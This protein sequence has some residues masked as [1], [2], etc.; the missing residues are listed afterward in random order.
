MRLR[1]SVCRPWRSSHSSRA[2][3][4]SRCLP[5]AAVLAIVAGLSGAPAAAAA[6]PAGGA[7]ADWGVAEGGHFRYFLQAHSAEDAAAF[8]TAYGP[9]AEKALREIGLLFATAPTEKIGVYVYEDRARFDAAVLASGRSEIAG[10]GDAAADAKNRDISLFFPTL[11]AESAIQAENAFRHATAHIV[12]AIAS[13]GAIPRGFDEGIAQ[14]VERPVNERIARTVALVQ[15]AA[16]TGDRTSWFDINR[17]MPALDPD[18]LAAQSYAMTAFL[19]DRYDIGPMRQFLAELRTTP[20]WTEAMRA[21]YGRPQ[22][23][24]ESQWREDLPRWISVGWRKNL[25]AAFDL[26]PAKA[27]LA[28]ANYAAAKSALDPSLTLYRQLDDPEALKGVEGLIAQCDVGIQSESLMTQ[29]Q[30]ALEQ[31]TYD[32]AAS[33]LRQ[34]RAQYGQLPPAQQPEQLLVAYERQAADGLAAKGQL[35]A[36]TLLSHSWLDYR[37]AQRAALSAGT[38]Y[39]RLGDAEGRA[40]AAGLLH[41]LDARQRR[42]VLLLAA[43]AVL[44]LGWLALWLWARGRSTLDWRHSPQPRPQPHTERT[45]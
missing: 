6:P 41:D 4:A 23:E 42:I 16:A 30:Q 28:G 12:T 25:V 17:W 33:L 13:G 44:T 31:H 11:R 5:F 32:R 34:A 10:G 24:I 26:D 40:Q 9:G 8:V 7:T 36:A 14:Y 29:T 19:L 27:L 43:L 3:F 2:S 20:D 45:A 15:N 38:T 18:V 37:Q 35:D 39:A 21:A 22:A 1:R